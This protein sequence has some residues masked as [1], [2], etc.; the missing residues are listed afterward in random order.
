MT[1]AIRQR[2][3]LYRNRRLAWAALAVSFV[4]VLL[5]EILGGPHPGLAGHPE[6][7]GYRFSPMYSFSMQGMVYW[8]LFALMLGSLV[9]VHRAYMGREVIIV[10]PHCRAGLSS[11]SDWT[12][13]ACHQENHPTRGGAMNIL[14]TVLTRCR[15]CGV[16]PEAMRCPQ[17]SEAI[18]LQDDADTARA[19]VITES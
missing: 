2:H 11:K 13:P 17:C 16:S 19:A 5:W 18:V 7:F 6:G 3:T 1:T 12:C 14:Y 8:G 10:C 15:H 4:L 9:L